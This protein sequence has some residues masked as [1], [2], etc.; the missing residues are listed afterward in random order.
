MER[1]IETATFL[2]KEEGD[3]LVM[4]ILNKAKLR[5]PLSGEDVKYSIQNVLRQCPRQNPFKDDRPGKKWLALYLNYH[6]EVVKRNAEARVTVTK[7]SITEWFFRAKR[8]PT[9]YQC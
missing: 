9:Q 2:S 4:Y 8:V 5:F 7:K 3:E 1:K 6:P